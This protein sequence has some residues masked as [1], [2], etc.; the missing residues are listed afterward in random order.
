MRFW[1]GFTLLAAQN[2]LYWDIRYHGDPARDTVHLWS[3][4]QLTDVHIGENQG[5]YGTPG[6]LDTLTGAEG[7]Y[8][9]E[10]LRQAL[11]WLQQNWQAEKLAFIV[12]TGD[13]TDS[14]ERSEYLRF[15]ALMDSAGL[16]YLP[17][18]GNHDVWPYVSASNEAS[19]AWGD[20]LAAMLFADARQRFSQRVSA[21]EGASLT[22]SVPNPETGFRSRFHNF[23]F[24]YGGLRF[25]GVDGVSRQPAPL[26][27]AGVGPQA[28]L[29][30]FPGGTIRFLDT[31]LSAAQ[32]FPL[33]FLC[34][35]PLL[36]SPVSGANSFS[37]QEYDRIMSLLYPHRSQVRVWIA[38]H[39]HRGADYPLTYRPTGET[40]ARCVETPANKD[41][42]Q[43]QFR[44]FRVWG[45]ATQVSALESSSEAKPEPLGYRL[46]TLTGQL[47]YEGVR[48]PSL[49]E[50]PDGVYL[51]QE[52]TAQGLRV[53]A[54]FVS[55][56]R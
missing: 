6:Y 10:A 39:L 22:Y 40:F 23:T 19:Y 29:H 55:G 46:L 48:P 30:D 15:R 50:W 31:L 20:S 3:F 44:I 7:G 13:L 8:S 18:I 2:V 1:W 24:V 32:P 47:L 4:V 45:D 5:D 21:W 11:H 42:T 53:R 52:Q 33:V 49:S 34:H 28:D 14:G 16:P 25:V 37:P 35:Y 43:G 26:G 41:A 56:A 27:Q 38:G 9:V 36:N 17:L 54:F 12:V 51:L